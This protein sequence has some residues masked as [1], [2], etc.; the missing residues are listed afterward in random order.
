MRLQRLEN[1]QV[2][3][4]RV[5]VRID[6]HKF[7]DHNGNLANPLAFQ[8]IVPTLEFLL[9]RKASVI[10]LTHAGYS[11]PY[12]KAPVSLEKM[13]EYMAAVLKKPVCYLRGHFPLLELI[14]LKNKENE[15]ET[16]TSDL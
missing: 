11:D 5:L 2:S 13:S 10:L 14:T 9:Q 6:S 7:I 1:A 12:Q 8:K 3:D 16:K 15:S 4:K